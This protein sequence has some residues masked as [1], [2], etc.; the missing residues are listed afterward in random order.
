MLQ[1]IVTQKPPGEGQVACTRI[2]LYAVHHWPWSPERPV[3]GLV[4]EAVELAGCF[5][6][7]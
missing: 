6:C 2:M 7:C 4:K 5:M 3:G 1:W